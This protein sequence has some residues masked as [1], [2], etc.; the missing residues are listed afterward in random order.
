MS[1]AAILETLNRGIV[2]QRAHQRVGG[3]RVTN[4]DLL[5][6]GHQMGLQFVE[7]AFV[8]SCCEMMACTSALNASLC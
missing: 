4:T 6:G 1:P 2:D 7:A 5:I 8:E 3:E